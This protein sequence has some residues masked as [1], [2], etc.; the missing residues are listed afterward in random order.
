MKISNKAELI[1]YI[2]SLVDTNNLNMSISDMFSSVIGNTLVIDKKE[3]SALKK[4][5][6]K[7]ELDLVKNSLF[8]YWEL[9]DEN[10]EDLEIFNSYISPCVTE[11]D[12]NEYQS[13]PYYR[14]I[15]FS[16]IKDGEY[17]LVKDH[18]EAYELFAYKDME[19]FPGTYIEKNSISY[20][21]NPVDFLA[22]NHKKTT[23]MSITPN[24]IKTMEKAVNDAH[25][26]VIVYGLG[27]GYF[28]Y[29]ISLKDNVSRI[30]IIENDSTIISLFKKHILPQFKNKEKI[31]IVND[32]AFKYMKR[33][34]D[35]DYAFIDLWHDP[36][37]GIELYL[38]S[39]QLEKEGKEY[40]YW[41]ESSFYILLRRCML[42]LF[43][44]QLQGFEDENYTHESTFT[45]SIINTYYS[46]IKKLVLNTVEQVDE[47]LTDKSLLDLLLK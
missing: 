34:D 47:L 28:P 46:K 36:Y 23:W 17:E 26:K 42:S 24:E 12:I 29:M 2:E 27:L 39:K 8:N 4:K 11:I 25:G 16:N 1:Q 33:A 7:S 6:N 35:F 31:T 32:D 22:V 3:L 37:D 45:D 5:F 41:L 14:D 15:S 43:E 21:S 40:F 44:E 30:T 10:E 18:Y 9:D 19:Y 38:K 20:F 13:N